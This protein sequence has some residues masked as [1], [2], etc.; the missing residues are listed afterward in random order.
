MY[1]IDADDSENIEETSDNDE[2]VISR[3]DKQKEK[4]APK[5]SLLSAENSQKSS[6]KKIIEVQDRWVKVSTVRKRKITLH[7]FFD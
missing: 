6:L 3:R 4:K 1:A 2:E 7:D 5:A